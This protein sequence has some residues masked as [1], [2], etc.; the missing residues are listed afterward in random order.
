MRSASRTPKNI[1]NTSP[2]FDDKR[3]R[4]NFRMFAKIA[5]D[6]ERTN[7]G[8]P[9]SRNRF[10]SFGARRVDH[11][12]QPR[13]HQVLFDAFVRARGMRGQDIAR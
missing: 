5:S 6:H 9:R 13:E 7:P 11:A 3:Y 8:P 12:D 1:V 2:K 10:S 4:R